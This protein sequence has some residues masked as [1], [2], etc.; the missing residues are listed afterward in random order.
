LHAWTVHP[1]PAVVSRAG[2][3]AALC[4]AFCTVVALAL[5][6]FPVAVSG[7]AGGS[8][9]LGRG[10]RQAAP[11][12]TLAPAS[13]ATPGIP[14]GFEAN[15]G[16][17][18]P[19]VRF[20][21][22]GPG[23]AV[24]LTDGAAVV[25]PDGGTPLRVTLANANPGARARGAQPLAGR[26]NYLVGAD[27]SSWHTNVPTYGRVAYAGVYPGI[28]LSYH[29][30][31]GGLEYDFALRAGADPRRIA[32]ELDGASGLR[33]DRAGNLWMRL[34]QRTLEQR[35]PVGYQRIGGRVVSVRSSFR[36]LGPREVGLDVGVHDARRA[37]V[38]DPTIVYSTQLVGSAPGSG[39]G[40]A[41]D[42]RG[43]SFVTGE[44]TSAN[45]PTEHPLQARPKGPNVTAFV[46]K[47]DPSGALVYAT[48]L[49]GSRYTQGRGIAVDRAGDAFV[50]GATD[51]TDFPT[52]RAA[53]QPSYGGGPF[54]AFVTKLDATGTR[55][56]YSTFVGDTHYDESNA[57]AVDQD[58]R[59][60]FT[61]KTASPNFPVVRPLAPHS[62]SGAFVAKLNRAGSRLVSS[63]VFGGDG[64]GNHADDGYGI[65]VDPQG[66]TYATGETNDP[67]F[68]TV[69]PL[70]AALAGGGNAFVIKINAAST[71]IVYATYLGGSGDDIGRAIAADGN[72]D[73][74]VTG[75]T[76]SR[77]FPTVD[78]IA[79]A[80]ASPGPTGADAFVAKL[81]PSGDALVYSTYLGG[82]ADDGGYGI[83]LDRA[84][85]AYV[86][87]QT[88]SVDFPLTSP[89]QRTLH[90]PSDA[91][92][93]E[94][95][96]TGSFTHFS[97]YYGGS[98]DDAGQ[99]IAVD[100]G[101]SIHFTGQTD[102]AD[103]PRR[104]PRHG[105]KR[106]ATPGDGAFVAVL[107]P[108]TARDPRRRG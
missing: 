91:F 76:T 108:A 26:V 79:S 87:G 101:G 16:Q 40:I 63:T 32:I 6:A 21:S 64:S 78:A 57:I 45:F 88:A 94:L 107:R 73:A 72:G 102:S 5:A 43:D 10:L 77:D 11:A 66:D 4:G 82:S 22:M 13:P 98:E 2:P 96:R 12:Q 15:V 51:S 59:A 80:N 67:G 17:S 19:R 47:L 9:A 46:A 90:G 1:V 61:G 89:L 56:V 31:G 99:A 103:F 71:A 85:D 49:G 42:A 35:R 106:Y 93:T 70:Q 3:G 36:M 48:Y 14:L 23:G 30:G 65:A 83:A 55:L 34:G 74:Y 86:T 27:R 100:R 97:T 75:Q 68:P 92:V 105:P 41:V 20:L 18:D 58:D 38:I 24:F 95:D 44:T 53:F 50:T 69:R 104:G 39:L 81:D 37:L 8:G 25:A 29:V 54:D 7:G 60:V 52:T 33:V 84:R 62:S 28:D